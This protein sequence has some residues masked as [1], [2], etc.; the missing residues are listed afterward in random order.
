MYDIIIIGAGTAG[1]S[2]A[3][4]GVRAGKKVLILEE[5]NYGG[6]IINS[7]EIEN[8]P[9]IRKISGYEFAKN[10][11][12]QATELGA[13]YR[14]ERVTGIKDSG[15]KKEVLAKTASGEEK[16]YE[17]RTVILATGVK[18]RMLGVEREEELIGAGISYCATCDGMFFRGREVAVVGGGNTALED[19]MFLSGYCKQVYVIHRREEFRG[20]DKMVQNLKEKENVTVLLNSVVTKLLGDKMLEGVLLKDVHTGKE[21]DLKVSGVFVAIGQIPDNEAFADL[22]ETDETGY[23]QASEDCE[24]KVP[25]I[26]T[27]GD[28][29]TK[30]VRQLAT[31]ASDGAVAALAACEYIG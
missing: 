16:N 19:A 18:R 10:L 24:T 21:Q 27:A 31:A 20:E 3:I 15:E 5:K 30:A 22:V 28:C 7:P 14:Q 11:F 2:A 26:Y 29:R 25:G 12:E 8:Y 23:I 17:T 9:G 13:E 6:Q 4:Y 1:L